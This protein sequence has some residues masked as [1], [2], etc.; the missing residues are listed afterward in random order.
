MSCYSKHPKSNLPTVLIR[1]SGSRAS[2]VTTVA[3]EVRQALCNAGFNVAHKD[4]KGDLWDCNPKVDSIYD[5]R[6]IVIDEE[7]F[8]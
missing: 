6:L 7:N 5:N 4:H 2:G 3:G 1:I 8:E